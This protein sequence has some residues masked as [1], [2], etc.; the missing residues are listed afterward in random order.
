MD[1]LRLAEFLKLKMLPMQR[2]SCADEYGYVDVDDDAF[3]CARRVEVIDWMLVV[4]HLEH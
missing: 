2:E 1:W 3:L 4:P